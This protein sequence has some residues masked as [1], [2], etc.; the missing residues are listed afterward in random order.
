[1][2]YDTAISMYLIDVC[3]VKLD[4]SKRDLWDDPV[5]LSGQE[6][7]LSSTSVPLQTLSTC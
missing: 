3:L 1:M 7:D 6:E 2:I 5:A 4:G